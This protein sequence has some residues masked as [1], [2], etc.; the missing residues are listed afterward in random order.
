MR[1][2]VGRNLI[3]QR[4]PCACLSRIL[5]TDQPAFDSVQ[6]LVVDAE[7]HDGAVL[8][9][10]PF[11]RARPWRIAFEA[12]H[13]KASE[14]YALARHLQALGYRCMHWCSP[15]ADITSWH[16]LNSSERV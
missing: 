1:H 4:V 11:D 13:L 14:Y 8:H 5:P 3:T 2:V 15:R 6:L 16:H 10:W 7:G 12:A 9:A